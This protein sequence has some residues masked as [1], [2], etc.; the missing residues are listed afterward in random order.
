MSGYPTTDAEAKR[1]IL[2]IGRKLYERGFVAANDGNLSVRVGENAV[3][4]TPTGV[5]KGSMTEEMLVKLD[6]DGHVLEGTH[7]PSSEVKMHLRVYRE[8][9]QM[10]GVAHA[11]PPFST[12]FAAAGL[13]LDEALIQE[14]V[15]LVGTVPVAPYAVPALGR[16]GRQRCAVLP[17]TLGAAARAPRPC[18][19]GAQPRAGVFLPRERRSAGARDA[20]HAPAGRVAPADGKPD[21]QPHRAA[22][23]LGARRRA[24]RPPQGP[25]GRMS[26]LSPLHFRTSSA[27]RGPRPRR[28]PVP[29]R[30][31]FVYLHNFLCVCG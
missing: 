24:R 10:R 30:I 26:A 28:F 2:D 11:H 17:Y 16:P 20:V 8:Q 29:L 13:A 18:H 31:F 12:T 19:L 1:S 22:P 6:L 3:W 4:A 21:R 15:V 5:S 14:T 23:V 7:K 27:R 9:P 25:A